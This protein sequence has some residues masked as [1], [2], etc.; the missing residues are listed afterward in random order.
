MDRASKEALFKLQGGEGERWLMID[1]Q[2]WLAL[3]H[4][5]SETLSD[6]LLVALRY[7]IPMKRRSEKEREETD[8][9]LL[10]VHLGELDLCCVLI[11]LF[12][13]IS[14]DQVIMMRAR[15]TTE[16]LD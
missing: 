13:L 16:P 7:V 5:L 6:A 12:V 15:P 4:R 2:R 1:A 10:R 3:L 11:I 9:Q 8:V 14:K